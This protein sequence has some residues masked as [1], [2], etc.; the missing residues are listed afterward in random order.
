MWPSYHTQAIFLM[1]SHIQHLL[2]AMQ[3]L[4]YPCPVPSS[5]VGAVYWVINARPRNAKYLHSS[6]IN[7]VK[8]EV[9]PF[10]FS[11]F[12]VFPSP[13]SAKMHHTPT[14][15]AKKAVK[16]WTQITVRFINHLSFEIVFHWR[17][18]HMR[19]AHA[20]LSFEYACAFS[21]TFSTSVAS[22]ALSFLRAHASIPK[23]SFQRNVK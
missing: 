23:I 7:Q 4:A 20:R 18:F 6:F 14:P 10:P 19:Y 9:H 22:V 11:S 1:K 2:D 16:C 15:I 3:S 8:V 17:D 12:T 13:H 5:V 21:Q